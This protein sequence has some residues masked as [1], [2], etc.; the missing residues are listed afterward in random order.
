M[1]SRM[2][3]IVAW[4][5]RNRSS[6]TGQGTSSN[7]VRS[8][9]VS[10]TASVNDAPHG[11][12]I[13]LPTVALIRR[14]GIVEAV[15]HD[16]FAPGQ[17]RTDDFAHELRAAGVHQEQFGFRRHRVV[18]VTVL[19]RVA[20]FLAD[21]RAARLAK[22]A[23]GV[24]PFPQLVRPAAKPA[25]VL[26]LPSVP[27]NVMNKPFIREW[28]TFNIEHSTSNVQCRHWMLGVECWMFDVLSTFFSFGPLGESSITQ[29]FAFNSSRIASLR[30]KSF[31][32]RAACRCFEQRENLRRRF[33]LLR[34][35][36]M[37]KTEFTRLPRG[38][39]GRRLRAAFK[40][41]SANASVRF[42][43]PI[44]HRGP[45][46]GNVQVIVERVGEA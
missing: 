16:D 2:N 5:E 34:L 37:P 8:G 33:S 19:E 6:L 30:L 31:A 22:H 27:S 18:G 26:P 10:P 13:Q 28:K 29:P 25:C 39:S 21:G 46:G 9:R 7:R 43:H 14:G 23:H 20:D 15:A 41:L 35:A 11:G 24:A 36:P 3:G 32:L 17:R 38:Q 45:R 12:Q 42:A 4:R 1:R 44:K 40:E